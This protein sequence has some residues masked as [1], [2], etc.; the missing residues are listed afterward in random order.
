MNTSERI[1]VNCGTFN[2][3]ENAKN[4]DLQNGDNLNN[5]YYARETWWVV[6]SMTP[7]DVQQVLCTSQAIE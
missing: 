3:T 7:N 4:I 5:L 6:I 2:T 1:Q